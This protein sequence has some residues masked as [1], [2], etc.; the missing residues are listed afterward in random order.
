MIRVMVCACGLRV[1][2]ECAR[3]IAHRPPRQARAGNL[4]TAAVGGVT[5]AGAA[6]RMACVARTRGALPRLCA[7]PPGAPSGKT[8]D[9]P[10]D[11]PADPPLRTLII[12]SRPR[13]AKKIIAPVTLFKCHGAIPRL[14]GSSRLMC[15]DLPTYYR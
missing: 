10:R 7:G 3:V 9:Q 14:V 15:F 4:P 13:G 5:D 11:S 8:A 6:A 12:A 2:P 1:C